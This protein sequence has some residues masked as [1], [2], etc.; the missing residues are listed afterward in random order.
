MLIDL[1]VPMQRVGRHP[2]SVGHA[3]FGFP[4]VLALNFFL[5]SLIRGHVHRKSQIHKE[6]A[7]THTSIPI[8]NK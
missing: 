7:C 5:F 6:D 8:E 1:V 2:Q 3:V 4:L